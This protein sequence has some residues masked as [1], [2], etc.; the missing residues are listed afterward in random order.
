MKILITGA[1]GFVGQQ[2]V[3][4][5]TQHQLVILSRNIIAAKAKLGEQHQYW[6]SSS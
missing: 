1:T 3:G 4:S 5:L 6:S 2:L